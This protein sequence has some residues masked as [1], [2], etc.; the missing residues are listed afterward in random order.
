M[1]GD[2]RDAGPEQAGEREVICVHWQALALGLGLVVV[3]WQ[4]VWG[5]PR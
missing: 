4:I 2:A 5:Y 1:A 3:V